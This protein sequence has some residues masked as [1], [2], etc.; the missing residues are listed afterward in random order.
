VNLTSHPEFDRELADVARRDQAEAG[1]LKQAVRVLTSA[2]D[3]VGF[4]WTS[5]VRGAK[6]LREL[7]PRAG[8]SRYRILYRRKGD[9]LVLLGIAPEASTD[10]RRFNRA[11]RI[12]LQRATDI[13]RSSRGEC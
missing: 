10:P 6:G 13:T 2:D 3:L 4:P 1:A 7:R 12:A 8:R 5:A 9:V 11:C